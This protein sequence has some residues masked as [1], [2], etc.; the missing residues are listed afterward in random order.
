MANIT[1]FTV[2][3][4]FNNQEFVTEV[5]SVTSSSGAGLTTSNRAQADE[6]DTITYTWNG[7]SGSVTITGVDS[8]LW[9]NSG[10]TLSSGNNVVLTAKTGVAGTTDNV[11]FT[12][13]FN[14]FFQYLEHIGTAAVGTPGNFTVTDSVGNGGTY[15]GSTSTQNLSA[16]AAPA[17]Q[18]LE[19][20][21]GTGGWTT[22]TSFSHAYG[23]QFTYE[24]RYRRT[25]DNVTSTN[26]ASITRRVADALVTITPAFTVI[27]DGA[28]TGETTI[29]NITNATALT[30]YRVRATGNIN[31]SSVTNQFINAPTASSSTVTLQAN[32][33]SEFPAPGESATYSVNV[34]VTT[35]ANNGDGNYRQLPTTNPNRSFAIAK[36]ETITYGGPPATNR[37][38]GKNLWVAMTNTTAAYGVNEAAFTIT[39]YDY[40]TSPVTETIKVSKETSSVVGTQSQRGTF[41]ILNERLYGCNKPFS[42]SVTGNNFAI[43][44]TTMKGKEFGD[45]HSRGGTAN[46]YFWAEQDTNVAVFDNVTGGITTDGTGATATFEV[47][48][49]TRTLYQRTANNT[50]SIL[51]AS[52]EPMV[53]SKTAGNDRH[54]LEPASQ[55]NYYRRGQYVRTMGNLNAS[56]STG[57]STQGG[58]GYNL[59]NS[60]LEEGPRVFSLGIGDNAGGDSEHGVGLQNLSNAYLHPWSLRDFAIT[61]PYQQTIVVESFNSGSFVQRASY[62]F[63]S[64][65]IT[66]PEHLRRNGTEGFTTPGS[67]ANQAGTANT[68]NSDVL[69]RFRGSYPFHVAVNDNSQDEESLFGFS[70]DFSGLYGVQIFSDGGDLVLDTGD[71]T[72]QI[73]TSTTFTAAGSSSD[74]V[75]KTTTQNL[76]AAFDSQ[77]TSDSEVVVI[78]T[79]DPKRVRAEVIENTGSPKWAVKATVRG[80]TSQTITAIVVSFGDLV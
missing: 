5:T 61:T 28:P 44:P 27:S 17:G 80:T 10:L 74:L 60:P 79:G 49:Y 14:T 71:R 67:Y 8:N 2:S 11:S 68:F 13:N 33:T 19:F 20:R 70:Q 46:Y 77:V 18:V 63:S 32:N 6:G 73:V 48:A 59:I 34:R 23:Q 22:S 12:A 25:S 21:Q 26:P 58:V 78:A 16:D 65:T 31:G 53:I 40:S 52:D 69:W 3:G 38:H 62:T 55:Y 30:Q 35:G 24:A 7:S 41:S 64:A 54:V 50:N 47:P 39:E 72:G 4:F 45:V 75:T 43:V 29:A 51:F 15:S 66:L 1:T 36:S 76:G 37:D 9:T 56:N 57:G 42:M